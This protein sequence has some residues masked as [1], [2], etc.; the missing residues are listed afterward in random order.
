MPAAA[1]SGAGQPAN[2]QPGGPPTAE[3]V[4]KN[5]KVLKDI[6][7]DQLFPS[8]QFIA[9]SLGVECDFCHVHGHFEQDD[10]RPKLAARE[11][12]QLMMAINANHFEGRRAV[13]CN[14]CHRGAPHPV[15]IPLVVD[16]EPPMHAATASDPDEPL[17]AGL[18]T[19][20]QLIDQYVQA[21]GGRGAIEKISSRVEK[22]NANVGGHDVPVDIFAK[23]P[24]K[25]VAILHAPEGD[26]VTAFDGQQGWLGAANRPTREMARGD[27]AGARMDADLQ[28][29]VHLKQLSEDLH[30]GRP[31]KIGDYDTYQ[32]VAASKTVPPV[33]LYFDQK[34]GLLVRMARYSDT[35]LGLNAM[36]IDY[37]DYR[38]VDGV[39][40]PF[41]W[42]V[43]RPAGQFTIQLSD[44]KQNVPV[45]DS[46]F[47]KPPAPAEMPH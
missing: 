7:A 37:A 19:A 46:R 41:R 40:V 30:P 39:K 44:V 38:D 10:K 29:P 9:A 5:L 15:S 45:E 22:G 6:P 27:L 36:R 47:V 25:R 3:H 14:T 18:P 43:A 16:S 34:T 13:T 4:F 28:L 32:L 35:A 2:G 17:P 42:T 1:Q 33:Q 21:L 8:M 24:G 12:M 31:E 11:M 26:N 20:D 23:A